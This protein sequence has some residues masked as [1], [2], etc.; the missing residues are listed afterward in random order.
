MTEVVKLHENRPL[1][2][3]FLQKFPADLYPDDVDQ[4]NYD[5]AKLMNLTVDGLPLYC[6]LSKT[7]P[8]NIFTAGHTRAGGYSRTGKYLPTKFIPGKMDKRA[9]K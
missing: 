9:G 1:V 6:A 4:F 2:T 8:T 5:A 3:F 7:P